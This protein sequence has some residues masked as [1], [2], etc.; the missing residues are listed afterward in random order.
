MLKQWGLYLLA[1]AVF[2]TGQF[3][4]GR[5][6]VSGPPPAIEKTTLGG[7][8]AMPLLAKGPALIYFWGEWCG[9]CR[10]IQGNIDSVIKDYPAVTIALASGDDQTL[11]AY[12]S[13]KQLNWQTVNDDDGTISQRYG[14]NAVPALLITDNSGEIVFSSVGY[15]SEWGLRLRLWLA[16]FLG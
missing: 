10:A 16:G 15:T 9:I 5:S 3:F 14:V 2:L 4:S 8:A 6:L 7:A 11:Q 1:I 13:A 12:L